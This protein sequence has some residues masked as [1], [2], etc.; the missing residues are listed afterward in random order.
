M[1]KITHSFTPDWVSPP[2]DTILDLLEE[3]NLTQIQLLERL[4]YTVKHINQLING[5]APINEEIAI[6]LEQ[7]LGSTAGFWLNR[8]AQYR[9]QLVNIKKQQHLKH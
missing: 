7:V 6:K 4:G 8:E 3:H 5:K 2:G 9:A 1:T